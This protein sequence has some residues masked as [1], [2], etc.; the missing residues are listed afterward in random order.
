VVRRAFERV[1]NAFFEGLLMTSGHGPRDLVAPSRPLFF[2][3]RAAFRFFFA[4]R[5]DV[6]R[7]RVSLR[8]RAAGFN[9]RRRVLHD[10]LQRACRSTARTRT[11]SSPGM[12][13]FIP[14][15]ESA[16]RLGRAVAHARPRRAMLAGMDDAARARASARAQWP[17][18]KARLGEEDASAAP[19]DAS[20]SELF[21]MVWRLTMDA[22]AMTGQ[23]LPT[24][25]R[26]EMPGR[27]SRL[28]D[29]T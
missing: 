16:A 2:A 10:A 4:I 12:N 8:S 22:W 28:R 9:V 25:T 15:D 13:A 24:Y 19:R 18:G 20:P 17:G 11:R 23:P 14:S 29:R 6:A 7:R 21:A 27:V 26:A 1:A 3:G 5:R